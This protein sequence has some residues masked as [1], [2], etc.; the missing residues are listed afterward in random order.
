MVQ[1][2]DSA[3]FLLKPGEVSGLVRT[4]FGWHIIKLTDVKEYSGFR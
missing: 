4:P 2:F 3:A 1:P